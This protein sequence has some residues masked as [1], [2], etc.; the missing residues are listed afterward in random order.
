MFLDQVPVDLDSE[1]KAPDLRC[2]QRESQSKGDVVASGRFV[3]LP[4]LRLR[5]MRHKPDT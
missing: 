5:R 4:I 2:S 3:P 1:K